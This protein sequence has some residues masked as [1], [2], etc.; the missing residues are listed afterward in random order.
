M[1]SRIPLPS[2][3]QTSTALASRFLALQTRVRVETVGL[4]R[5]NALQSWQEEKKW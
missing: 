3:T 4:L 1:S 5:G 2:T